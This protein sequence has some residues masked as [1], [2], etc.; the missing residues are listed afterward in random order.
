MTTTNLSTNE[1]NKIYNFINNTNN[2]NN[3]LLVKYLNDNT[4]IE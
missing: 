2:I 4:N 1:L 3:K